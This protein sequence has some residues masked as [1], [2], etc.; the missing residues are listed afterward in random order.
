MNLRDHFHI[1]WRRKWVVLAVAI[2][3]A[4]GVYIWFGQESKVYQAQAQLSVT[5]GEVAS[6]AGATQSDALFLA[7]TY[8]Q[9]AKTAP[10]VQAAV[11]NSGLALGEPAAFKRLSV[12]ASST[13]GFIT[14][15]ATGPSP[16]A[17]TALARGETDALTA[18]VTAQQE[19]ALTAQLKSLNSRIDAV[20]TQ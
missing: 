17:A 8:A 6:G 14:V 12:G 2:L 1:I 10:V 20:T 19:S 9:L 16:Q 13:V 7:A 11:R 15:T 18:S 3:V 4:G 5:P